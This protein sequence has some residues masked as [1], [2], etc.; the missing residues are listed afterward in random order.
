MV[1]WLSTIQYGS[2]SVRAGVNFVVAAEWLEQSFSSSV[3]YDD[4]QF[5]AY[6]RG[7][8]EYDSIPFDASVPV[9]PGNIR[10]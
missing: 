4:K 10:R 6:L 2:C 7:G 3:G 1:Q 5:V 9:V 8:S